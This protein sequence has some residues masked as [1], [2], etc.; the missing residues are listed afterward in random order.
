DV[1]IGESGSRISFHSFDKIWSSD[2]SANTATQI[3][4]AYVTPDLNGVQIGDG[5]LYFAATTANGGG[6]NS[7]LWRTDGTASGT[8][9]VSFVSNNGVK[10]LA[11]VGK[12]VFMIVNGLSS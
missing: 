1:A 9:V 4:N 8:Q 10:D 7:S 5:R 2:G 3:A 12:Y 6:F 11:S